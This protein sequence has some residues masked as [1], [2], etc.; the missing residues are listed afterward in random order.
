MTHHPLRHRQQ[1]NP[2]T[3]TTQRSSACNHHHHHRGPSVMIEVNLLVVIMMRASSTVRRPLPSFDRVSQTET[4]LTHSLHS[5]HSS[6]TCR[7]SEDTCPELL[8]L[9]AHSTLRPHVVH[10][11]VNPVLDLHLVAMHLRTLLLTPR[12]TPSLLSYSVCACFASS[13]GSLSKLGSLFGSLIWYS[14]QYFGYPNRDPNFDNHPLVQSTTLAHTGS[15][16]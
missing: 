14:T 4:T 12:A 13:L 16:C 10:S 15:I 9:L 8:R 2:K 1:Q 3:V 7:Q 6:C 11:L 5:V